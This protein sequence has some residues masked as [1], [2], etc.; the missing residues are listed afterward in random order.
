MRARGEDPEE[1]TEA[2]I[3]V[4]NEAISARPENMTI[5]LHMCRG[6]LKGMWMDEGGY[7]PIAEK[8]FTGLN[9]DTYFME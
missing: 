6:N 2:Y 9:V 8:L 3:R 5:G 1:L 7:G 4:I